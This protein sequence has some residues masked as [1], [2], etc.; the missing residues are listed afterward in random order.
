MSQIVQSTNSAEVAH[1]S[2]GNSYSRS[3]FGD[4]FHECF[5]IFQT[6]I[7]ATQRQIAVFQSGQ[8]KVEKE[9]EWAEKALNQSGPPIKN[10][11]K[12]VKIYENLLD[13]AFE[14]S[15]NVFVIQQALE[16]EVEHREPKEENLRRGYLDDAQ[17]DL[18]DTIEAYDAN[19]YC[20]LRKLSKKAMKKTLREKR[21][22]AATED[23]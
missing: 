16:D 7:Y 8:A 4:D 6:R 21:K 10:L 18:K 14:H 23:E 2:S 19:V 17:R 12:R 20:L 3:T 1:H 11:L 15:T 22:E 9:L 13:L 5:I